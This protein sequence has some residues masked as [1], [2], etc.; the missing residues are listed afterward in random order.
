[1]Q[2]EGKRM[3]I[4]ILNRRDIG[5][6]AGGGAEIYTHE[7]ARGLT[8]RYNY[9]VTVL[10]SAFRGSEPEKVI[11]G[12]R[13]IREGNEAT[14]HLRGFFYALKN[15]LR[16]NLIVDEFNGIGFFTFLFPN[17]ILLI[18]QLYREF[19]FR[20]LGGPGIFPY[21]LESM[22][23]RCYSKKTAITV[24]PSTEQDL[25][26]IGFRDT[27]IVMNAIKVFPVGPARKED[28]P[29]VTF[30]GRLRSTKRPEDALRIFKKVREKVPQVRL[31]IIGRGP[32]EEK[33]KKTSEGVDNIIFWGWVEESE[34]LSLLQ[35]SHLLVVPGVREGFGINVI[36]AASA[37]T[38]AVGY[39][40]PGLRDS[41][42]HGETGFLADSLD[43]AAV[44]IVELLTDK[45]K[46]NLMSHNCLAYAEG[47]SWAKRAEEFWHSIPEI[48]RK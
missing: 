16:F 25:R 26:R 41:I 1:M 40:V 37:G 22:L 47:F 9:S 24:S 45:E 4:L 39:N 13:Y 28:Y 8:E 14:V 38:P 42:R 3:K 11:E 32:E 18:H 33:L 30:L 20:E 17:S 10:S 29:I 35:R 7:I 15:R 23:L 27:H 34:K 21:I 44:R 5:N 31:W 36:E 19:W 46:Y 2:L 12:V 48:F 6:P 43:E